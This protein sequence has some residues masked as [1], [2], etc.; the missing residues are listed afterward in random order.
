MCAWERERE[1]VRDCEFVRKRERDC[2]TEREIVKEKERVCER[3]K[4]C[5][6]IYIYIYI[7]TYI[8]INRLTVRL[9]RVGHESTLHL[10]TLQLVPP[11][12]SLG[13]VGGPKTK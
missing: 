1:C 2:A 7:Y 12:P 4:A 11:G 6:C 3:G 9:H 8:Y 13:R 10:K 5:V